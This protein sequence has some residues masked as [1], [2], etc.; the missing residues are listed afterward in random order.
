MTPV[1]NELEAT[2]V[3]ECCCGHRWEA[4]DLIALRYCVATKT[5]GLARGCVCPPTAKTPR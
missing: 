5:A 3:G 2:L 1:V 4:H